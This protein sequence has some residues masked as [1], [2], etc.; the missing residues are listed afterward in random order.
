MRHV[1]T[2]NSIFRYDDIHCNILAYEAGSYIALQG[3]AAHKSPKEMP[4]SSKRTVQI[5]TKFYGATTKKA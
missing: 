1:S 4:P 5:V 2:N 3:L